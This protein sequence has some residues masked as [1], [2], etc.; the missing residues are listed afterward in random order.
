MYGRTVHEKWVAFAFEKMLHI[1]DQ[2]RGGA[3]A[4]TAF[5]SDLS[6]GITK[7]TVRLPLTNSSHSPIKA[8]VGS[9]SESLQMC[10]TFL[11]AVHFS[12][13]KCVRSVVNRLGGGRCKADPTT[14]GRHRPPAR[15]QTPPWRSSQTGL[16]ADPP[17]LSAWLSEAGLIAHQWQLAQIG[18]NSHC[19]MWSSQKMRSLKPRVT[20]RMT[21]LNR[22]TSQVLRP[23]R[24]IVRGAFRDRV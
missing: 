22:S 2:R 24:A 1:D 20:R 7:R 18:V 23:T 14:Q 3:Q 21:I 15:S 12:G 17:N 16:A 9:I 10:R 8:V 6:A 13:V 5:A 4:S 11:I 19:L